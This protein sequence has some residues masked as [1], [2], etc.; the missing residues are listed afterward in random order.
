[1]KLAEDIRE[2]IENLDR[3]GLLVRIK[4]EINK[5]TEVHPIVRW[6][7]RG[8]IPE[9]MRKAFL[10]ENVVDSK[11]KR[12]N[13]PNFVGGLA[14]SRQIYSIGMGCPTEE[15]PSRWARALENPIKPVII[16]RGPVQE[17]IHRG[18]DL[19]REG[20]GLDEFGVPISTPGFDNA[21]YFT[22][23][24]WLTKDPETGIRNVGVY[25]G[26]IKGRAHTGVCPGPQ[27]N[28]HLSIHWQKAKER[29]KHLEAAMFVGGPPVV[30]YAV[31]QKIPYGF[32]ELELA[33]GLA[34]KPIEL[35]K[36]QTVDLEVPATAEFVLEGII[37]T[38]FIEPEGAFGESH[39]YM[40]PRILNPVFEITCIT[41]RKRPIIVSYLSQVTPSE[42][43]K[44]KQVGYEP[45]VLHH[46]QKE[47]SLP[48][49][50]DVALHEN[51]TNL[52]R[53]VVIQLRKPKQHDVWRALYALV[54]FNQELGRITVAVD[55]DIDPRDP[56]SVNWALAYRMEPER[57]LRVLGGREKGHSPPFVVEG[58][59]LDRFEMAEEREAGSSCLLLNA[60]LKQKFPPVA[61]PKKEFMEWAR[62]IWEEE[63]LPALTPRSP[64]YGYSLGQWDEEFEEEARLAV[65]GEY[66]KTGE[67]LSKRRVKC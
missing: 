36:C 56:E 19:C 33:G 21:P 20:G 12:Y 27:A 67:K 22:A 49:V 65:Q 1:M 54:G 35:V 11:G 10:F 29:G 41:H 62:K 14:G 8:G 60:T 39:G 47:C 52:R 43:S 51:L 18:E 53:Y 17:E 25:R 31:V 26:H 57:D 46:L 64:W 34:G 28:Q 50:M 9:E 6:Q 13:T 38:D 15:I 16:S 2:H 42:S 66:Y 30:C 7:Y 61:L 23:G 5:D 40:H 3:A 63:G 59:R 48:S 37:R 4:R 45:L 58:E 32:D 55:E 24:Q 44:I